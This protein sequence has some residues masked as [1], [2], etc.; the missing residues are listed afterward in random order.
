MSN[1]SFAKSRKS[2]YQNDGEKNDDFG[3]DSEERPERGV[4]LLDPDEADA[5]AAAVVVGHVER[6]ALEAATIGS[7]SQRTMEWE[8]SFISRF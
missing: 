2:W 6:D 8:A 1:S 7:E 4:L 5:L 3:H